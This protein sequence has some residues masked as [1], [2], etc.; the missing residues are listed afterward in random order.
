MSLKKKVSIKDLCLYKYYD[1]LQTGRL[2]DR[3]SISGKAN[4]IPFSISSRPTLG[5]TQSPI[6]L[7]W[8]SFPGSKATRK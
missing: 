4:N 5:P 8:G 7:Y 6:N 2:R 1:L 3:S